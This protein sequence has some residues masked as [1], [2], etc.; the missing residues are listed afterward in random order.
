[1]SNTPTPDLIKTADVARLA[2]VEHATVRSWRHRGIGPRWFRL[3]T[4]V[5]RYRRAEVERW[6][7]VNEV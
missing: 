3:E 7:T 5:V 2:N 6:L 4:G 1:M